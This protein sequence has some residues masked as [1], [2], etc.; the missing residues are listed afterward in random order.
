MPEEE[1]Q[2]GGSERMQDGVQEE[3]TRGRRLRKDARRM[4]Q[5][6]NSR[7]GGSERMQDGAR[8]ED[9]RVGGSERIAKKNEMKER[10]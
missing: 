6:K 4:P 2:E 8:E 10:T 9:T 1:V 5:E 7:K 3:D